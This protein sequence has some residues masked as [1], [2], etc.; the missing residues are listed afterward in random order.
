M[1]LFSLVAFKIFLFVFCFSSLSVCVFGVGYYFFKH[2]SSALF[3]LSSL[4]GILII[5][6][7]NHLKKPHK[8]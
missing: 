1:C 7:L 4:F 8:Y 6:M 2:I 5:N 3:S